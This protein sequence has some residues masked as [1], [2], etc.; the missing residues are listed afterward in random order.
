MMFD[1][2]LSLT[3]DLSRS[4]S[5]SYPAFMGGAQV[6]YKAGHYLFLIY[7]K[8]IHLRFSFDNQ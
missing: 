4:T 6:P 3:G 2:F 7:I 1:F 5:D 8:H